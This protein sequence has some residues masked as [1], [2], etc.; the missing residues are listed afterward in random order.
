VF[1]HVH[2]V[3]GDL[4]A[5]LPVT[6]CEQITPITS[7]TG[8]LAFDFILYWRFGTQALYAENSN[9]TFVIEWS[10][11]WGYVDAQ[12]CG[13]GDTGMVLSHQGNRATFWIQDLHG[14]PMSGDLV[15]LARLVL[16][17]PVEGSLRCIQ[18]TGFGEY[19]DWPGARAGVECGTCLYYD[20]TG[21]P[22][23]PLIQPRLTELTADETGHASGQFHVDFT[24][25][26]EYPYVG[27]F[28]FT[29]TEPWLAVTTTY[30]GYDP[31]CPIYDA[32]AHADAKD[33][34]PGVYE[35]WIEV[36]AL[37]CYECEKVVLTVPAPASIPDAGESAPE[38]WGHVKSLFR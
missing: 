34:A 31:C 6:T 29:V 21:Y 18:Q 24:G 23:I 22:I 35:G 15:G 30:L 9:L 28:E 36:H 19:P 10:S 37:E 26:D 13:S 7:S 32:V 16:S 33:L 20:C 11:D 2:A 25:F 17:V 1:T 5:G 12:V 3:E 14:A 38:T 8:T 27:E 4:C